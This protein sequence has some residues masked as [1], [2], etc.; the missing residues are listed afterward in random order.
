MPLNGYSYVGERSS[1][2]FWHSHQEE[3]S[4]NLNEKGNKCMKT[5]L[6][7]SVRENAVFVIEFVLIVAAI[8]AVAYLIEYAFCKKNEEKLRVFTTPKLCVMALCSALAVVLMMF[9]VSVFFAPPFYKIDLSEIP[10]LLG[11]YILG[12]VAG[13]MIEFVKILLE[14][15]LRGTSTAFVGE[16]ANFA[17]GCSLVL[18]A[19]VFHL[20]KR[21]RKYAVIG[22]IMGT[23]VMTIFGSAFNAVYLL[24]KFAELYGMPLDVLIQMGTKVNSNI[25]SVSTM[26]L[27][28]VAPLNLLKGTIV[29]AFTCAIYLPLGGVIRNGISRPMQKKKK[30]A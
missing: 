10:V 20:I 13:V 23:L 12:P 19:S 22:A 24:P 3:F 25:T 29:S 7:T 9:D 18:P 16:L 6:L 15:A 2:A 4:F 17:V 28:A 14:V 30:V 26:A 11:A 5:N 8:F 21:K 1:S 27:F